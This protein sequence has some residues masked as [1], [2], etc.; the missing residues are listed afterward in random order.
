MYVCACAHVCARE[1][2]DGR[3]GEG[4]NTEKGSSPEWG[5]AL[6]TVSGPTWC[7]RGCR[8]FLLCLLDGDGAV[9]SY[10]L[11]TEVNKVAV[12]DGGCDL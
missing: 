12:V 10:V 3:G 9:E 1:R 11:L 2:G 5:T 7:Q 6:C 4:V 8:G